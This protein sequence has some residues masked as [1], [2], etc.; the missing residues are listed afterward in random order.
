MLGKTYLTIPYKQGSSFCKHVLELDKYRIVGAKSD[1]NVTV[2]LGEHGGKYDRIIIVFKKDY[3]SFDIRIVHDVTYDTI[4]LAV[5]EN[6][7]CML[8]ASSTELELFIA[9]HKYETIIDPPIDSSMKL[10]AIDNGF[11]FING[12][13]IHQLKKK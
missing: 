2:I 9:A 6:G 10:F 4:N 13:S 11:F 1:K 12:N 7:I 5:L 3:Q 8:L